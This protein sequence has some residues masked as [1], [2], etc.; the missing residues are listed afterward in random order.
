MVPSPEM[1]TVSSPVQDKLAEAWDIV[2][3][4]PKVADI[5][6]ELDV[7]GARSLPKLLFL[8]NL[9]EASRRRS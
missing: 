9:I 1:G 5:N 8:G 7:V 6:R 4:D 3:E 2:K